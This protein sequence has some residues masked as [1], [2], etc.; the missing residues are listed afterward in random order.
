MAGRITAGTTSP[1]SD[2]RRAYFAGDRAAQVEEHVA[3]L[4]S[5]LGISG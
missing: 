4:N 1:E 3:A 5:D 2:F